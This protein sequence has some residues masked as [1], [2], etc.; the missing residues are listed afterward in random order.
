M[1][2][3]KFSKRM[4]LTHHVHIK[5]SYTTSIACFDSSPNFQSTCQ[6]NCYKSINPN[7]TSQSTNQNQ[8]QRSVS[9]THTTCFTT[10]ANLIALFKY[11]QQRCV[12]S[13]RST[14]HG[15]STWVR[16]YSMKRA[17]RPGPMALTNIVS[18][19]KQFSAGTKTW[20]STGMNQWQTIKVRSNIS[21]CATLLQ[22]PQRSKFSMKGIAAPGSAVVNFRKIGSWRTLSCAKTLSCIETSAPT[23]RRCQQAIGGAEPS[24]KST[25]TR[26]NWKNKLITPGHM[27]QHHLLSNLSRDR[28]LTNLLCK[29]DVLGLTDDRSDL[30][31]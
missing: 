1:I 5:Q 13:N 12:S 16:I 24:S 25:W 26:T 2:D 20:T 3:C 29:L 18:A 8:P 9:L 31:E 17:K 14:T 7:I 11:F 22:I 30:P 4:S 21:I 10:T 27:S 15:V 28:I 23:S 6:P 19:V